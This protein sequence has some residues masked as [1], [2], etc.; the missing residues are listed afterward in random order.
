MKLTETQIRAALAGCKQMQA[1]RQ[2][3][4][5]R[6]IMTTTAYG[7]PITVELAPVDYWVLRV[8]AG[9]GIYRCQD[10]DPDKAL[11]KAVAQLKAELP[12]QP[13]EPRKRGPKPGPRVPKDGATTWSMR[14]LDCMRVLA[15]SIMPDIQIKEAQKTIDGVG[16]VVTVMLG[17]PCTVRAH[18]VGSR[19]KVLVAKG[20]TRAEA[21][22]ALMLRNA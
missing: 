20:A 12:G 9:T 18:V 11:A 22:T 15:E 5:H 1:V 3:E 6:R 17:H 7:M 21:L 19:T 2:E 16:V 13:A 14:E 4:A 8:D 10:G